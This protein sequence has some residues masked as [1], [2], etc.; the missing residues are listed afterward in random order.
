MYK[1]MIFLELL[2]RTAKCSLT[3]RW[4]PKNFEL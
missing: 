4:R 3:D 2:A 1:G